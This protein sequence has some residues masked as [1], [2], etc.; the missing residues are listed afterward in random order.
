MDKLGGLIEDIRN[1]MV[2]FQVRPRISHLD[3]AL[4]L[5]RHPY[6]KISMII[7]ASSSRVSP[8]DYPPMRSDRITGKSG[9]R[10]SQLREYFLHIHVGHG[11]YFVFWWGAQAGLF[12]D[13]YSHSIDNSILKVTPN[14]RF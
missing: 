12:S 4:H 11:V 5:F 14:T 9:P 10:P 8:P 7:A 1:A 6:N 13:N 2:I 3:L